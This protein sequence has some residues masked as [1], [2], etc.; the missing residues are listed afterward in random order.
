MNITREFCRD[1]EGVPRPHLLHDRSRHRPMPGPALSEGN[2]SPE[3]RKEMAEKVRFQANQAR[4]GL[5][6]DDVV[7]A[8][9]V[10]QNHHALISQFSPDIA[11]Y[12]FGDN[13]VIDKSK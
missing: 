1:D 5:A 10:I 11:K 3:L 4:P 12:R 9:G 13:T 7:T 2:L 8:D 6:G